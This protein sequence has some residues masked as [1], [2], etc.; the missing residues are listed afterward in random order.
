M[1]TWKLIESITRLSCYIHS[2]IQNN[3]GSIFAHV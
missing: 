1:S 3:Q 2:T